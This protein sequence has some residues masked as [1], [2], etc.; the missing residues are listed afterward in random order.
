MHKWFLHNRLPMFDIEN[1]GGSGG[2]IGI[3]QHKIPNQGQESNTEDNDDITE[4]FWQNDDDG[5]EDRPD[6]EEIRQQE[7]KVLTGF[8]QYVD[9]L[10]LVPDDVDLDT[11]I[12]NR[13]KEG[14]K[15][16]LK[17]V[18]ANAYRN[19]VLDVNKIVEAKIPRL[20]DEAVK[21]AT[22][23]VHAHGAIEKM[24]D[25]LPYT[26]DPALRPVAEQVL[27]QA[28]KRN[29]GDLSRAL[30]DV[31]RYFKRTAEL[32]GGGNSN[33]NSRSGRG[34]SNNKSSDQEVDWMKLLGGE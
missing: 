20:I 12:D 18:G 1:G 31:E 32:A 14:F 27:S 26:K 6:P 25:K 2:S 30:S 24:F 28:V 22:G 4:N 11:I 19:A 21:R 33:G 9:R 3:Q 13:D 23:T 29:K 5:Q 17:Q 8:Q 16:I 34:G 7:E 10:N 15:N